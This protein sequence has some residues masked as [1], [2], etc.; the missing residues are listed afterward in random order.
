MK[1]TSNTTSNEVKE[2]MEET[3]IKM[4]NAEKNESDVSNHLQKTNG[5]IPSVVSEMRKENENSDS[6][7]YFLDKVQNGFS[8]ERGRENSIGS[9]IKNAIESMT[10]EEY[11]K[12]SDDEKLRYWAEMHKYFTEQDI[13]PGAKALSDALQSGELQGPSIVQEYMHSDV[14]L[15]GTEIK[16]NNGKD[17]VEKCEEELEEIEAD[18]TDNISIKKAIQNMYAENQQPEMRLYGLYGV[19]DNYFESIDE[20]LKYCRETTHSTNQF[21]VLD[22]YRH[23]GNFNDVI[24]KSNGETSMFYVVP[25]ELG[26]CWYSDE[27]NHQT[28]D[29]EF[30]H[31]TIKDLYKAFRDHDVVFEDDIYAREDERNKK[32]LNYCKENSML[33]KGK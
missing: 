32:F 29:W 7:G 30:N 28:D 4:E 22:Y 13:T 6:F 9:K 19:S 1:M 16:L 31:G 18:T 26:V 21:T 3:L 14:N 11:E 2:R 27:L 24:R 5:T 23:L 8:S 12:L 15:D 17:L 33:K 20:L 10:K 25:N